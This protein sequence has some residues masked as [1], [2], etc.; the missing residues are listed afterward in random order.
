MI[1]PEKSI[2]IKLY[3]IGNVKNTSKFTSVGQ[4][5]RP[6]ATRQTDVQLFESKE[7]EEVWVEVD[8]CQL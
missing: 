4:I 6:D 3:L 1:F 5:H 7:G 8:V 2:Q